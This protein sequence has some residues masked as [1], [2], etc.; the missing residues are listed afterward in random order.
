MVAIFIHSGV[1]YTTKDIREKFDLT[2]HR[3]RKLLRE[4]KAGRL[5]DD[6]PINYIDED[7]VF[8]DDDDDSRDSDEDSVGAAADDDAVVP[9]EASTAIVASAD[10]TACSMFDS[11]IDEVSFAQPTQRVRTPE[12]FDIFADDDDDDFAVQDAEHKTVSVAAAAEVSAASV[13]EVDLIV[14]RTCSSPPPP[15]PPQFFLCS[16]MTAIRS[17]LSRVAFSTPLGVPV[18]RRRFSDAIEQALECGVHGRISD[19]FQPASFGRDSLVPAIIDVEPINVAVAVVNVDVHTHAVVKNDH[20]NSVAF[21][22]ASTS[23]VNLGVYRETL[24]RTVCYN[25]LG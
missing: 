15:P 7:D 22:A 18:N 1:A 11:E 3:A 17:R 19:S 12:P 23:T 16:E 8:P 6:W 13:P 4:I 20:V 14:L 21:S 25:F 2:E 10:T 24:S 5:H 9:G